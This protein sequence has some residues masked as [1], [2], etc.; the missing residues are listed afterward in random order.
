MATDPQL[1]ALH[2]QYGRCLLISSSRPRTRPANL[3]GVVGTVFDVLADLSDAGARTAEVQY[4]AGG[5]VTHHVPTPGAAR[6]GTARHG[7]ARHRWTDP[8]G[9]HRTRPAGAAH[10]IRPGGSQGLSRPAPGRA[11]ISTTDR[12]ADHRDRPPR[13]PPGTGRGRRM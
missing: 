13:C 1:V 7:T 6:H 10:S 12:T 5:W 9:Q 3:Q 11:S 2:F 4:G 8:R